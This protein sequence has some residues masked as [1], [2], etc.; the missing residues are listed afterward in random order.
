RMLRDQHRCSGA[1]L[2]LAPR[3]AEADA[4][5]EH[6]EQ[7]LRVM[8]DVQ[9]RADALG[10]L[11]LPEREGAARIL[12]HQAETAGQ[13]GVVGLA[14]AGLVNHRLRPEHAHLTTSWS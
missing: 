10:N 5:L 13:E 9:G 6:D 7:L 2:R 12:R 14:L 3:A 11:L 1:C 4:A 8:V